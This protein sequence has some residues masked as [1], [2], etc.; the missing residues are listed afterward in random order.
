LELSFYFRLKSKSSIVSLQ[1]IHCGN[2]DKP[3]LYPANF[4][5]VESLRTY[6]TGLMGDI[7]LLINDKMVG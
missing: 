1:N 6:S 4:S 7:E 5:L 3:L 2:Q